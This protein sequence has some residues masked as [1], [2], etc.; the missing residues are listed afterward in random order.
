M[1]LHIL[2]TKWW[3]RWEDKQWKQP[4]GFQ[5]QEV[6]GTQ[7]SGDTPEGGGL[8]TTQKLEPSGKSQNYNRDCTGGTDV[9]DLRSLQPEAGIMEN[10]LVRKCLLEQERERTTLAAQ[11][12][13][14]VFY[15][16]LSL[17]WLARNQLSRDPK[18]QFWREA[19]RKSIWKQQ[20]ISTQSP[21]QQ[22]Q[23]ASLSRTRLSFSVPSLGISSFFSLVQPCINKMFIAIY[24]STFQVVSY[25]EISFLYYC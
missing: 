2:F 4:R 3:K 15:T 22:S 6:A 20:R 25:R 5:Q 8:I 17:D 14:P 23:C 11:F 16:C 7:R 1:L 19:R 9:I 21:K 24:W 10:I 13:P 18:K 12:C